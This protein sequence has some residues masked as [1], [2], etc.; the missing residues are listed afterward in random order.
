MIAVH[1]LNTVKLELKKRVLSGRSFCFTKFKH[2]IYRSL[3]EKMLFFC[4]E[5]HHSSA[6]LEGSDSVH[7]RPHCNG[8]HMRVVEANQFLRHAFR[9]HI[10]EHLISSFSA[11]PFIIVA[12][13]LIHWSGHDK[14][15]VVESGIFEGEL[16]VSIRHCA[17]LFYWMRELMNYFEVAHQLREPNFLNCEEE[18]S[19]VFEIE[20]NG[21]WAVLDTLCDVSD[22]GFFKALLQKHF[23]SRV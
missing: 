21:R 19:F 6:N 8:C 22:R 1:I 23:S 12:F 5:H 2:R 20:V 13:H 10:H 15:Q 9:E 3:N 18:L 14:H 4:G 7:K 16:Q 11:G 17:Q